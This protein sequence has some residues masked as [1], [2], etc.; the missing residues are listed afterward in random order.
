MT[1]AELLEAD[2]DVLVPA[3]VENVI[4]EG[5]AEQIRPTTLS[6]WLMAGYTRGRSD[7]SSARI[8]SV[9]DVLANSGGVTVSYF[10]WY[11]N[12]HGETWSEERV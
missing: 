11:Q 6:R 4:T 7:F 5:N 1:N 3:A 2:T 8:I 9:P 12:M 10:E